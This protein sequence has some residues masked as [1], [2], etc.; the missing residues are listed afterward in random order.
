MKKLL[1]VTTGGTIDKIHYDLDDKIFTDITIQNG[2]ET[3]E[4]QAL[5]EMVKRVRNDEKAILYYYFL[6]SM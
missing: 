1:I 5:I 2:R 4:R 6:M 3:N